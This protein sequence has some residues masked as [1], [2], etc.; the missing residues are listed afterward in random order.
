MLFINMNQEVIN[1]LMNKRRNVGQG[2]EK[3]DAIVGAWPWM[4][5]A[6]LKQVFSQ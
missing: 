4:G 5:N 1:F 2:L 3:A 6:L